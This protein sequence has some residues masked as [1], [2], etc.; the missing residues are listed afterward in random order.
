MFAKRAGSLLALVFV[1]TG[2]SAATPPAK[3]CIRAWP[4]ARFNGVGFNH[5]VHIRNACGV[6]ADCVVTT[7]VN[8]EPTAAF[9]PPRSE[10]V[11]NTFLGSPARVFTPTV[12]CTMRTQ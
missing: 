1:V 7:D 4:V 3:D 11:V 9:V 6:P 12:E 8:P 5:L 10:T 2:A